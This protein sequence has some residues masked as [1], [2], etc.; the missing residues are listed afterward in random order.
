M[1]ATT[2][3]R[4]ALYG[5]GRIYSYGVASGVIVYSGTIVHLG[6]GNYLASALAGSTTILGVCLDTVNNSSTRTDG[7][8]VSQGDVS[9]RV[10]K[11]G[12]FRFVANGTPSVTHIGQYA[13]PVDNQT[14][15]ITNVFG[16]SGVGYALGTPRMLGTVVGFGTS[17]YSY[18]D[19]KL[20]PY[21]LS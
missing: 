1:A 18:Y 19:V 11:D 9:A 13:L 21:L 17:P 20:S 5:D 7:R 8:T 15:G 6:G 2:T 10:A 14:V 16:V 12:I 3:G 4:D